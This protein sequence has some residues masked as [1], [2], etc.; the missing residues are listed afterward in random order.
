MSVGKF[1]AGFLVGGAVGGIL[2]ILLAPQSGEDTRGLISEKSQ[3][4]YKDTEDSFQELQNKANN[5]ID[6]IQQKGDELLA[7]IH[8]VIKEKTGS[9]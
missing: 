9:V 8:D 3:E 4:F 1:M 5:V 7:K 2:G 6:D